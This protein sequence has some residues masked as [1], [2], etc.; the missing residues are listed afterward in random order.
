MKFARP[1]FTGG[2]ILWKTRPN[3]A[4]SPVELAPKDVGTPQDMHRA[5]VRSVQSCGRWWIDTARGIVQKS[6]ANDPCPQSTRLLSP[7]PNPILTYK[8][9]WNDE[10]QM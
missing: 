9:M 7:L 1:V 4:N 3:Y 8:E 5:Y 6:V 10:I 2:D